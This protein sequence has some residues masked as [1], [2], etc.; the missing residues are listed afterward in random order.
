MNNN[1]ACM[2]LR[3]S[4]EDGDISESNSIS[5]QR[6]IIKSYAKENGITISNE[7]VDDG[8]SGSNFDR[9]NFKNMIEDLNAGKFRIIIV[10]D[11]S[12][13]GRDYIESGKYLQKIFP[14]KGI[15]FI[16]VN[17]NYDSDNADV[18]DTHLILPI[19]NFINDSYCRD[20]SMKVKSS[21]EVKRKNGEFIGS[22]APFGYKKD[23]KNKHKLVVDTEVSHIV[24]R[25]FDMKIEGYSSKAIADFLN[26]IGT[27]TP[28]RHKENKGDNFNTGFIVKDAKWDA[29]MVNRVI[30]NKVYIGVLEQGKTAKLNY[31]SKREVDVAKD[32]WII[33]ENAHESIVS[34]SVFALANKMLLRDVK[35][36]KENPSIL[37]GML[38]C[39]D[40]G[41]PMIRRKVKSKDGYNIFYVCSEY[42]IK[43]E[44]TRHSIKEDYVIGA[45]VHALNDYLSKYNELLKKVS[46]I[47]VSKLTIKADFDSLNTEK[48]K[49]ERLRGSLYMDLEEELITTE[50][51]ERFR[52]NYLLK[53]REIKKQIITKQKTIEELTEKI[54]DKGSFVSD[55]IPNIEEGTLNR[56][57]LVSFI[58]RIEIGED[59]AIN[60]V[61]NNME[62]VNLMQAILDSEKCECKAS[63]EN[64]VRVF[65]IGRA[66]GET[67][68]MNMPKLA[69]GGVC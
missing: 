4:R 7:Y 64:K 47:D 36:S 40:C 1:I 10:K 58:D 62:T 22:F 67:L 57:S 12:R 32:D 13:F 42:N 56:L 39:K 45:T 16:S 49:Y 19:R 26:S 23:S 61:F 5:N 29:K 53:I 17:D 37:S 8:F 20:I 30:T 66:Y 11:L 24:S 63:D 50:E 14:E 31:K 3:L 52:K 44:C 34:K 21:K 33:I 2:Y 59:N 27:V 15:R 54:K 28:S 41:S 46:K 51:F 35:A 6:Q 48:K 60:F 38:Y 65:T 55:I 25:I 9:P 69:G 43:G 68:E 18:S